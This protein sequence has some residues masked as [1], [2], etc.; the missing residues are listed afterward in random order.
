MQ[1]EGKSQRS[2]FVQTASDGLTEGVHPSKRTLMA[3]I[4]IL[5]S[6]PCTNL[7]KDGMELIENLCDR[8]V[9]VNEFCY[10]G[11]KLKTSKGCSYTKN[12]NWMVDL[13][14]EVSYC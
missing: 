11:N 7:D 8:V 1:K 9:T 4:R 12:E 5:F 14:N 2:L 6:T 10:L 13:E 3:L